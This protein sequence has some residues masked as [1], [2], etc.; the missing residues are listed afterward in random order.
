MANQA[1]ILDT[2]VTTMP[3]MQAQQN[4]RAVISA[5]T[6]AD[7]ATLTA[8][9]FKG[10][11]LNLTAIDLNPMAGNNVV[12][13]PGWYV[14]LTGL[15]VIYQVQAI[16]TGAAPGWTRIAGLTTTI[17]LTNIVGQPTY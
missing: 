3:N 13:S 14:A 12:I 5:F 11:A 2:A 8:L 15:A 6:K 17:P 1:T 7:T 10:S 4:A 16:L 9:G